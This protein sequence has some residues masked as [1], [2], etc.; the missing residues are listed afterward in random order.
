MV[1]VSQFIKVGKNT[2][3]ILQYVDMSASVF[4]LHAHFPTRQQSESVTR[5]RMKDMQ[6]RDDLKKWSQQIDI[7]LPDVWRNAVVAT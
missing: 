2:V 1:D 4:A 5:R 7:P 6:W 3:R